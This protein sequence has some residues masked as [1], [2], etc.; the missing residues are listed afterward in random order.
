MKM[1]RLV[2]LLLLLL[3]FLPTVAL[4][5]TP[6]IDV[7]LP[8]TVVQARWEEISYYYRVVG[9]RLQYRIWSVTY[10]YWLTDWD[11]V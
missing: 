11:W 2:A 6:D 10:G 5:A 9:T 7:E 3:M 1:K 4:A 8:D